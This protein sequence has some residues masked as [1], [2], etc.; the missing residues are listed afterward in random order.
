M[1][2][3]VTIVVSILCSATARPDAPDYYS[4]A[5]VLLFADHLFQ[6]QDYLRAAYEYERYLFLQGGEDPSHREILFRSAKAFQC[7]AAYERSLE[8]FYSF[9]R[10]SKI[11][12]D[13]ERGIYELGL[14]YFRMKQY[15]ESLELLQ[16]HHS[17]S[18]TP[19]PIIL[20][21]AN[22]MMLGQ[23]QQAE[24]LL[25]APAIPQ[26]EP[27]RKLAV[28]GSTMR[29]KSPAAAGILSS[30]VPGLGK[31]YA[32]EY[33]DGMQSLLFIGLFGTLSFLSFR[34]EGVESV[35]GWVYASAGGILHIGNIYGSIV[36][37]RRYN[38]LREEALLQEVVEAI[39]PCSEFLLVP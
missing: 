1:R 21:A 19:E 5:S 37:A 35:R 23:W 15:A 8:L 13:Q 36:S 4:P 27:L 12:I 26:M 34:S 24:A 29:R 18:G 28:E 14:T 7:G 16:S 3:L 30:I 11:G 25:A 6:E 33:G 39:P 17:W 31:F 20:T 22:L 32:E 9:L 2:I 10:S 38:R